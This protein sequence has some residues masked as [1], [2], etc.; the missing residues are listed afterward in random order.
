[1]DHSFIN[2]EEFA[3]ELIH[4]YPFVQYSCAGKT[5]EGR[6]IPLIRIGVGDNHIL[7]LA[8]ED[9]CERISEYVLC[10][11]ATQLC[12]HTQR[13]NTVFHT[14]CDYLCQSRSIWLIPCQN[15]D[16]KVIHLAGADPGSFLYEKQLR[17][18][19][20]KSDFSAWKENARGVRIAKHYLS[21]HPESEGECAAVC[22]LIKNLSPTLLIECG[23]GENEIIAGSES[24]LP[25]AHLG[26]KMTNYTVKKHAP[27]GVCAYHGKNYAQNSLFLGIGGNSPTLAYGRLTPFLFTAPLL[28]GCPKRQNLSLYP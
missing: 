9:A 11:F 23:K 8:G 4:T 1:M 12:I 2:T 22:R 13:H 20:M 24:S 21:S 10:Q 14:N 26:A 16:G 17:Q 5:A 6:D 18:N 19:N 25:A 15:P 7:M 28:L 27:I 3:R